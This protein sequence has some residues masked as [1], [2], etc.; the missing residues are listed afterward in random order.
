MRK[1]RPSHKCIYVIPSVYGNLN[2]LITIFNTILPL[3]TSEGND[4]KIIMLGNYINGT[5]SFETIECLINLKKEYLDRLVLLKGSSEQLLLK[6][7]N[8]SKDDYSSW[9]NKGGTSTLQSYLNNN[10][11]DSTPN[12]IPITRLA[13]VINK[14]HIQFIES[15]PSHFL[16]EGYAFFSG[17]FDIKKQ[18]SENIEDNY[19]F[20]Y[21]SSRYLKEC[22][23]LEK[24]PEFKD[25]YIFVGYNNFNSKEPYL[26][27]RYLMLGETAPSKLIVFELNSMEAIAC[28]INKQ[29]T[30]KYSFKY[31]E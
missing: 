27:P 23:K 30:F 8:N 21:S 11:I 6:S 20:D 9:I 26:H 12:S 7:I 16:Y 31:Y 18:F 4:D 15:M 5:Q 29:K 22:L 25:E 1:W 28:N 2:S 17:G 13:D 10:K 3:R 19:I 24:E 14:D